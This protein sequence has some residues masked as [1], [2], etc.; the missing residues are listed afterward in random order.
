[1]NTRYLSLGLAALALFVAFRFCLPLVL[2]FVLAYFFAKML[3]PVVRF[4]SDKWRWNRRLCA[5]SVVVVVVAA[6]VGFIIYIGS[7]AISQGILLLQKIPVYQQMAS[8]SLENIC[9]QCDKLMAFSTGTSYQFVEVQ[10]T[11][12]YTNIG[13]NLLPKLS[14]C[15]ADII[16][17]AAKV[18]SGVFIF[19]LSTM[20]ILLDDTLSGVHKKLHP[21][22]SRLKKAG[23]AYIKAQS[24]ILFLIATVICTGLFLIG[25]DYAILLGISIAVLDAFP[26]LGSGIILLPWALFRVFSGDF[27]DAAVLITLFA[28]A[29]FLRE[30]MEPKLFGKEIGM[31][32]LYVLISIYVGVKLFGLGGILLGPVAVTILKVVDD[33]VKESLE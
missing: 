20:L 21:F 9:C 31:K 24:I 1:M 32:P 23:F 5:V 15:A 13:N 18:G 2:P 19:F 12:L 25:N 27:F 28:V 33:M 10:T 7:M 16:R 29:T 14:S 4:L 26:I 30:V 17:W 3:L 8:T 22:F 11:K 6:L